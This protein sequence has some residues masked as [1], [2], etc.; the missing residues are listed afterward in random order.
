M[1]NWDWPTGVALYGI[2]K[3]YQQSEDKSILDYL[4]N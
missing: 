3:T 4:I 2:Y 1:N